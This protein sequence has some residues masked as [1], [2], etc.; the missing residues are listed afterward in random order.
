MK[1]VALI[2][3]VVFLLL[4]IAVPV[5]A[6]IIDF[7]DMGNTDIDYAE[8]LDR[9]QSTVDS[10]ENGDYILY[11]DVYKAFVLDPRLFIEEAGFR[12]TEVQQAVIDLLLGEHSSVENE[13]ALLVILNCVHDGYLY[14]TP[15]KYDYP[16]KSGRAFMDTL[17]ANLQHHILYRPQAYRSDYSALFA[18][19][20][21]K[22][23]TSDS[24]TLSWDLSVSLKEAP[25]AF[26]RNLSNQAQAVK[27]IVCQRLDYNDACGYAWIILDRLDD[28]TAADAWNENETDAVKAI[29]AVL[30]DAAPLPTPTDP[31][32]DEVAKRNEILN[33]TEDTQ[34]EETVPPTIPAD[35]IPAETAAPSIDALDEA[36]TQESGNIWLVAF[37]VGLISIIVGF[38]FGFFIT[39]QRNR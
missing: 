34:P 38:L 32:P 23:D 33:S 28:L 9:V 27:D 7:I 15:S 8:L 3:S 12:N 29:Q 17:W 22:T 37:P 5:H 2:V 11:R 14:A 10:A 19:V 26:V 25:E 30:A 13:D 21:T 16:S 36:N 20:Y 39:K 35:T 31:D 4:T 24:Q 1:K 6:Q 18:E